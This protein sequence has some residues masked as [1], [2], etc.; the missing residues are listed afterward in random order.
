MADQKFERWCAD[1]DQFNNSGQLWRTELLQPKMILRN[2]TDPDLML[3]TMFRCAPMVTM[4]P[5]ERV[6]IGTR[7]FVAYA[8]PSSGWPRYEALT[9]FDDWDVYP[10]RV[11]SPLDLLCANGGKDLEG[12]FSNIFGELRGDPVP[13]LKHACDC[14]FWYLPDTFVTRLLKNEFDMVADGELIDKLCVASQRI[15]ECD[16]MTA[17]AFME[18]RF[19][20]QH[21]G[22]GEYADLVCTEQFQDLCVDTDEIYLALEVASDVHAEKAS[23]KTMTETFHTR[24]RE[25]VAKKKGCGAK[26]KGKGAAPP[27][28]KAKKVHACPIPAD[29]ACLS[30]DD[31]LMLAPAGSKVHKDHFN[32]RWRIYWRSDETWPWKDV[33]RSWGRRSSRDAA[34]LCLKV[35]WQWAELFDHECPMP[36]IL[37]F[38]AD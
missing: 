25:A 37:T 12:G 4:V 26:A 32:G 38:E 28:K 33:S 10:H 21:N 22:T 5:L 23:V 6:E 2:K 27:K 8:K 3:F 36:D 7:K 29:D 13:L 35:S 19:V 20:E 17:L 9:S 18:H 31:L 16:E 1:K 34:F 30:Q 11:C 24:V 15:K 14:G